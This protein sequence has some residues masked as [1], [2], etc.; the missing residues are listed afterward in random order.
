MDAT[1]ATAKPAQTAA[2]S[3]RR[4]H[5]RVGVS[6]I[7]TLRLAAGGV[8]EC[9]VIDLSRGGAKIA[10][11]EALTLAPADTVGLVVEKF[12]TFRAETVWRRG[13]FV[14]LRFREPPETIAAAFGNFLPP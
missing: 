3:E 9:L 13:V 10:L 2:L 11:G 4:R 7:A 14:G 12:G 6:F 8:A 5:A 1:A